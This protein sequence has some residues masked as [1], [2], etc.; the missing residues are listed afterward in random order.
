ME[1]ISNKQLNNK[2]TEE[3]RI[4]IVNNNKKRPKPS[5]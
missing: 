2:E 4:K 3:I 1:D 5:C